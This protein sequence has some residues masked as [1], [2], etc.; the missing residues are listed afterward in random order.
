M[1]A[2]NKQSLEILWFCCVS[3]TNDRVDVLG[4]IFSKSTDT[5][6][7]GRHG[8]A[9]QRPLAV[10]VLA[11]HGAHLADTGQSAVAKE[12]KKT[13]TPR[14]NWEVELSDGIPELP[15]VLTLNA[16]SAWCLSVQRCAQ[17]PC[18]WRHTGRRSRGW[19]WC[20]GEQRGHAC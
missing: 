11:N 3:L 19:S 1:S 12:E 4:R 5:G 18:R 20:C 10:H 8:E 16:G 17:C 13:L 6:T 2:K 14:Y 7:L 15:R 9:G